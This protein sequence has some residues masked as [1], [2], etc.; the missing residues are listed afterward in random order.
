MQK[1]KLSFNESSGNCKEKSWK[2]KIAFCPF[3]VVQHGPSILVLV[4]KP[5]SGLNKGQASYLKGLNVS[6]N[7]LQITLLCA[8]MLP[9]SFQCNANVCLHTM[10]KHT[11][12]CI[13]EV[14][15]RSFLWRP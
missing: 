6:L 2:L 12:P 10:G 14:P 5:S 1:G 7:V 13:F 4:E 15:F 3:G 11:E 8:K 9:Y